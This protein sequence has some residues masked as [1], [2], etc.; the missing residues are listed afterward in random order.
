MLMRSMLTIL[1]ILFFTNFVYAEEF[2]P[3]PNKKMDWKFHGITRSFDRYSIQRS[4][5]VYKEVCAACHSM[6]RIAFHNL[7]DVRFSEKDIKQICSF[8]SS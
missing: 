8:L 2:K 3:S 7:Q 4:Y 5:K 1:C 6:N